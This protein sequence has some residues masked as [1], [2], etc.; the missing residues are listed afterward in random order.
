M[1]SKLTGIQQ[2]PFRSFLYRDYRLVWIGATSSSIAN[3]ML[4]TAIA[5]LVLEI[6]HSPVLITFAFAVFAIPSIVIGPFAGVWSDKYSRK[7]LLVFVWIVSSVCS[8]ILGL[9][10]MAD[11][12]GIWVIFLLTALIGSSMP[13]VFVCSQTYIYDIVGPSNALNGISLWSLGLRLVGA[14][15]AIIGGFIIESAGIYLAIF[16]AAIGYVVASI[17]ISAIRHV[18]ARGTPDDSSV[19]EN[20]KSGLNVIRGSGLL[21]GVVIL[22]IIAEAFGYGIS[23][24]FPILADEG[25]FAV[26]A[27]GLGIMN[28]AFGIGGVL[29]SIILASL[30]NLER[31]GALLVMVL[32]IS[33]LLL[34][35]LSLSTYFYL[36]ILIIGGIGLLM[37]GYDTFAILIMQRSAPE[38]MRGR[39]TGVLVL[40]FGI[41][42]AGHMALGFMTAA[43]GPS[44]AIGT[45]AV[46]V[47]S[48]TLLVFI[49]IKKL[50]SLQS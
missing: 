29:G 50:R 10:V 7:K 45:S 27:F 40:T 37:A 8:I 49:S 21:I 6:T 18:D 14:A 48:V 13:M 42:P 47:I 28:G 35:G 9:L 15:G 16:V 26:G 3:W 46:I 32:M 25:V 30:R 31:L 44:L 24:I 17:A 22:A 39:L 5:W 11:F 38:G 36:A 20:L 12:Q 33:G 2:G 41:A 4:K 34:L 19:F 23:A 43:L 1:E